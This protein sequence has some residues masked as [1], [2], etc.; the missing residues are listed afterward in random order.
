MWS[1]N[2]SLLGGE[3]GVLSSLP[4]VGCCTGLRL[5]SQPL[6]PALTV[7]SFSFANCIKFPSQFFSFFF[8]EE[9][10]PNVTLDLAC[11]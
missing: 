7:A 4:V 11:S 2:L 6:P 1:S 9:I 5:D 3:L 10:A 8:P